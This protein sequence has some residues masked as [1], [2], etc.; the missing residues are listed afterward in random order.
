[1]Y[2]RDPHWVPPLRRDESRRLD[3][4]ANPFLDHAD[5]NLWLAFDGEECCGRIAAIEDRAHNDFHR[6]RLAWFGFFEARNHATAGELLATVEAWGR[7]RGCSAVRGPVNPS[8]NESAGLLVQGFEDDPC[9]LMPYNPPAYRGFIE[10]HG[11][12]KVKDLL[13][14]SLD[15]TVPLGARIE[16]LAERLRRHTDITVRRVDMKAFYR[17]VALMN[18]IYRSAWQDN[19]GFVPPTDA[20][21][22]QLATD[23]K[24]VVDPDLVLFAELRGRPIACA[25]ALPDLNQVL[26]RMKGRL[27]PFGLWHFLNR[28]AIIKRARL[29][30]LGVLA[31]HRNVGLYPLL[32]SEVHRRGVANGYTRGEL[33]WTLEDNHAVNAGIVATGGSIYKKYRL[34][35]KSLG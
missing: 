15:L 20:E 10:G 14:W 29:V 25:V 13:A 35:E 8:L 24:P 31:G 17:D 28:R 6:E 30:L 11:Y 26:K 27:F 4:R 19:W 18:D 32:I 22:K 21:M 23:L 16:R 5:M 3:R 12:V 34:Y 33:S 9:L 7:A 2:A 1:M